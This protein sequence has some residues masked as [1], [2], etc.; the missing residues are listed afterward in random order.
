MSAGTWVASNSF[1]AAE[2]DLPRLQKLLREAG[3]LFTV[4]PYGEEPDGETLSEVVIHSRH[5]EA[6]AIRDRLR[7]GWRLDASRRGHPMEFLEEHG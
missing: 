3:V 7:A 5:E 6:E 1:V 2:S 4:L